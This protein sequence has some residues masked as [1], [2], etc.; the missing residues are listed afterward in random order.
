MN[1]QYQLMSAE[2]LQ[3]LAYYTYKL[4]RKDKFSPIY[5]GFHYFG[6]SDFSDYDI[7]FLVAIDIDADTIVGIL[8]Y[9]IEECKHWHMCP[10]IQMG[11]I[12]TA[13]RYIDIKE[14]YK[15]LRIGST[16]I[17]IFNGAVDKSIPIMVTGEDGDGITY[18]SHRMFKKHVDAL[19]VF[20]RS[21]D[22]SYTAVD[23]RI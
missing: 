23:T 3:N 11:D 21:L 8:K 16:L 10:E 9:S 19:L 7:D 2:E 5:E 15:G 4:Q 1:I 17:Q 6:S 20:Y 22:C 12:F 13:M 18:G 14:G